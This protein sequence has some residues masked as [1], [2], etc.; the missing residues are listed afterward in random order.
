MLLAEPDADYAPSM[1]RVVELAGFRSGLSVP[2]LR[3]QQ[4]VDYFSASW[5]L[6][7]REIK[8]AIAAALENAAAAL[9]N[10]ADEWEVIVV[11][12]GSSDGPRR[13]FSSRPQALHSETGI[14][15]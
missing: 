6:S 10:V 14:N 9:K 5:G 8:A 2:L 11:D 3:D 12:D 7:K 13:S 1:K 15:M 4:I